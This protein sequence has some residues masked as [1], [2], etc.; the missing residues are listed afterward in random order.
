MCE[1][2]GVGVFVVGVF[3]VDVTRLPSAC[4]VSLIGFGPCTRATNQKH[5][6]LPGQGMDPQSRLLSHQQPKGHPPCSIVEA[7]DV[8]HVK[9][10]QCSPMAVNAKERN[11]TILFESPDMTARARD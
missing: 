7:Y 10:D 2:I 3:V 1:H 6:P 4:D 11:A 5:M 9:R 8:L